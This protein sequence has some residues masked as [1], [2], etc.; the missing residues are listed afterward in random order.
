MAQPVPSANVE[1]HIQG[2]ISGQV[3]V[4]NYNL[5]IGSIHGGVVNVIA[6]GQQPQPRPRPIPVFLRPRPF[7][8]LLDRAAE[9]NAADA[10][11]Q[12]AL[13]V[14]FYGQGGIGK[15]SL[16][17]R[18]A[19]QPLDVLFPDGILYF[20]TR[21][22]PVADLLQSL[23]DA[24]YESDVPFKPTDAQIRH[25]LQNKQALILLDDVEL[26]R[27]E[28]EALMN[29]AP[30]CTFLLA[31]PKRH[32]WGEGRTMA[33]CG[34]PPDDAQALM[35][36]EL[37]RPLTAEE[38][39]AAQALCTALDGH[40]LRLIQA[41][42]M[43]REEGRSLVEIAHR[44]QAAPPDRALTSQALVSLSEP[45]QRVLRALAALKGASLDADHLS[46]LTGLP[47]VTPTL[48]SLLQR[49]LV[50][51]HSP[52]YTLT[53]TLEWDLRQ[54]L[55]L[56]P[57]E[58]RALTYFTDW[59]ERH[60]SAPERL[61]EEA[62]AI[63]QTLE[64]AVGAGRW[65]SVQR[66]GRAMEGALVLGKR[67]GAW[68]QVL[69]W[70]LQA[71][72]ALGDRAIQAWA[73][74]QSGTR[75]LCL[76]DT[77]T[78]RTSLIHA[79]HL[80]ESLGD[81]IGAAVTRHNLNIL[82]GPPPPPRQPPRPPTTPAPAGLA[83]LDIPLLFTLGVSLLVLAV[84]GKLIIWPS[85]KTTQP[86]LTVTAMPIPTATPMPPPTL[87]PTATATVTGTPTPTTTN[88]PTATATP[89]NT[90]TST[91]WPCGAP[92]AHWELYTVQQGD[93]LYPLAR[94]RLINPTERE[95]ANLVK[96]IICYNRLL[97]P[98]LRVGQRLYLPPL[99]TPTP[100]VAIWLESGCNRE[101]NLGDQTNISVQANVEGIVEIWLDQQPIEQIPL[102]PGQVQD[103]PWTF[104]EEEP[105]EHQF[106]AILR[107]AD[108]EELAKAGCGFIL[109]YDDQGPSIGELVTTPPGENICV[110]DV[111]TIESIITDP[112]GVDRAE[113][114]YTHI[115]TGGSGVLQRASMSRGEGDTF[116]VT[117]QDFEQS[118]ELRYG[119]EAWDSLENKSQSPESTK[120]IVLCLPDLVVTTLQTTGPATL[121]PHVGIT[122]PVRVV[123]RNQGGAAADIFK[124]ST[125]YT[126]GNGTDVVPF[127]VQGQDNTWYPFTDTP[128]AAGSEVA[129][130]GV[131]T[132]D[133][134][135]QGETVP[136]WATAD[137]CAGDEYMPEYCRVEESD[138]ENNA[139]AR[140]PVQLPGRPDLTGAI[141]C[142][143][144]ALP[145]EELGDRVEVVLNNS[146]PVSAENF[147]VDLVLSSD[148]TIPVELATYSP[149]FSEDV[150]LQNGR[151]QVESI[152]GGSSLDLSFAP[153]G[154]R[155]PC[156][157]AGDYYLGLV[158]DS[159]KTVVEANEGNNTALCPIQIDPIPCPAPMAEITDSQIIGASGG[160]VGY[161]M[162]QL[163]W[164]YGTG[165][166]PERLFI[167]VYRFQGG[168]WDNI[169]PGEEPFEVP[170]PS[171][172]TTADVVIYRL[173]R[174]N[175]RIVYTICCNLEEFTFER[176][177]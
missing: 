105:G 60:R 21:R 11:L 25:A 137:S 74:H 13:P 130:V 48:E 88:T 45:E 172:T 122:V 128:L 110:G 83:A 123:V 107:N 156:V 9:I 106:R 39:S 101:Y 77:A 159:G 33:L 20:P 64:W 108:G 99:P 4:G 144:R 163:A 51:A 98:R 65:T 152:A 87:T 6:P 116:Y 139:S 177:L 100:E 19:Y 80:R 114:W 35:E 54:T 84:L 59:A 7:P 154:N 29:A 90:P 37:G 140:I 15:T 102:T 138:E 136:L 85:P 3:A 146:G 31:S 16:L 69:R 174:G 2:E 1:A 56:T 166:R 17:R 129:F 55:D 89:T 36:R 169:M 41:A 62:D 120:A 157:P 28:V 63:L 171:T 50:R 162:L 12:S 34:L 112:S 26:A 71:A 67:W 161:A 91:P 125:E 47:N 117:I 148:T 145:G 118:G 109:E 94:A 153:D 66:L 113:L 173:F 155:I 22:Q 23:Y 124:V 76:E 82:I 104:G 115:P 165:E 79:L 151:E 18:L 5:Q 10:A 150:L 142:P 46:A 168:E 176:E 95:V 96:L 93:G 167:T 97:D 30:G 38:Q 86:T 32:L 134:Y 14:E 57:W 103:V 133:Y 58:E 119:V 27:D 81:Q 70:M 49:G 78:A 170:S 164:T 72:R 160:T 143:T 73:L 24:F 42:A 52:R 8:G 175:Y 61:L 158:V 149:I 147:S 44:V 68:A 92:P 127:T 141:T 111:I 53:G 121:V 75:A 40:P 135:L 132:F 43:V 126:L 131:V